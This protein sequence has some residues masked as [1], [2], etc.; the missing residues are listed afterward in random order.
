MKRPSTRTAHEQRSVQRDIA[1]SALNFND[2][3][4]VHNLVMDIG[5]S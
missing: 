1:I 2:N 3:V 4:R 5:P